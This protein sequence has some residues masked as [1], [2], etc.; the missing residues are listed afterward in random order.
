MPCDGRTT[1]SYPAFA[2][3]CDRWMGLKMSGITDKIGEEN[4]AFGE[5]GKEQILDRFC[6]GGI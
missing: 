4:Q 3:G 5:W 2:E 6:S 1:E